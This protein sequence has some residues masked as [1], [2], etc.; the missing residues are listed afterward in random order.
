MSPARILLVLATAACVPCA[1][2]CG[3]ESRER[4]KP[5]PTNPELER[6]SK[7]GTPAPDEAESIAAACAAM[8]EHEAEG[9][10]T[11]G[12]AAGASNADAAAE[13]LHSW[14]LNDAR[15]CGAAYARF[16]ECRRDSLD[17]ENGW[18][19][20][21][22]VYEDA[23]FLCTT[24]FVQRTTCTPVNIG[25]LCEGSAYSYGCVTQRKPFAE[26]ERVPDTA[27]TAYCCF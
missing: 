3:E 6:Y 2:G 4:P 23:A 9:C 10:G 18:H 27:S 20:D 1:V 24:D 22:D 26:C 5:V 16:I 11:A 15:G 13:C 17:C 8:L 12:G 21:C 7:P 14:R 25:N 19:P